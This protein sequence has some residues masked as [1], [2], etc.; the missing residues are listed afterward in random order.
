MQPSTNTLPI[1]RLRLGVGASKTIQAAWVRF[2]ALTVE[3][4]RQTYTRLDEFTYR[5]ASGDFEA[6]L[7]V[8]DDGVEGQ[9][10]EWERTGVSTGPDDT[11]PLDSR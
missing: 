10:A 11:E 3:K 5:Y 6:E 8:D 7:V 1:R 9:Y 2:P 4:A